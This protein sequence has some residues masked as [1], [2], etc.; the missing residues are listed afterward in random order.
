MKNIQLLDCTLRDG[1]YIN[2]WAFGERTIKSMIN[3][4]IRSNVDMVE[5]GFL[6]DCVYDID[7]TLFNNVSEAKNI[8]PRHSVNTKFVLMSLHDKYSIDKLEENDGTIYAIRVTFHDYDVDEGLDFI[9]KVMEKGYRCFC[10]PINIMGYSD[11]QILTI[12]EKVNEIK[13]FGFSIVDTFGSMKR[14]DLL[15]LYYLCEKNLNPNITLGLHLH[16]NM[17]LAFSLAQTF[18]EN[19][20]SRDFVIDASLLGMGRVPGNLC[21]EL[22]MDYLNDIG[23]E[24]YNTSYALDAIEDHILKIRAKIAWGYSTE[25]YLSAKYNLHRNYAEYLLDKGKLTAKNIDHI[26]SQI[27]KSKKTAFDANYVEKL[28]LN[29]QDRKVDDIQTIRNLKEKIGD[30]SVL[31]LAPG[32]SLNTEK[33]KVDQYI[34][35]NAPYIFSANFFSESFPIDC[36][37]FSNAK[38][39]EDY[40]YIQDFIKNVVVTSNITK[41]D[42]EKVNYHD[43]HYGQVTT[44]NCVLM[45]INLLLRMGFHKVVLAGFD[46]YLENDHAYIDTSLESIRNVHSS[47]VEI[48]ESLKKLEQHIEMEVLT[49]SLYMQERDSYA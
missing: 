21:M 42:I 22:I 31:I 11:T 7:K 20:S 6:R 9:R 15:R 44:S 19:I 40:A 35:E 10:N 46:G 16:E 36:A 23:G 47:N 26:L 13:P 14:K 8:L 34:K 49:E 30:K 3:S 29:Y 5:V 48:I 41:K 28:Y 38:R 43:V 39:F 1:G 45:L 24:R 4:L 2:N 33:K 32:K 17:S 18:I 12:I 37:F 25:Y 27:D